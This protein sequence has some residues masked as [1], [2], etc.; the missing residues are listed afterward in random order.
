[1]KSRDLVIIAIII[2]YFLTIFSVAV[3]DRE[4]A[5]QS[6]KHMPIQMVELHGNGT[7][8]NYEIENT[9]ESNFLTSVGGTIGQFAFALPFVLIG[10][11]M[12]GMPLAILN[13]SIHV[14]SESTNQWLLFLIPSLVAIPAMLILSTKISI[15]KRI[16]YVYV[17]VMI[18][19]G[20]PILLSSTFGQ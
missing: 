13:N 2:G 6:S 18:I 15:W 19:S 4:N 11:G 7:A 20:T 14:L 10:M 1:M 5:K 3:M 17:F 8:R 12:W 9:S 16:L